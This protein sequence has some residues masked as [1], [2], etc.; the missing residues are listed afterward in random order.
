MRWTALLLL[1]A[2]A[3][4][5][6]PDRPWNGLLPDEDQEFGDEESR[7]SEWLATRI[8]DR[9]TG[10]PIP[11]ARLLRTPEWMDPGRLRHDMVM[12]EGVADADG[13]ARVPADG[14]LHRGDSHWLAVAPGYA[15]VEDYGFYPDP[16]MRLGRGVPMSFRVLDP[17][18]R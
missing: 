15:P 18:G 16:E 11:G 9:A 3:Q 6:E 5:A 4:D 2:V 8:L 1:A 17:L 12:S 14:H 10:R 7:G 13:I